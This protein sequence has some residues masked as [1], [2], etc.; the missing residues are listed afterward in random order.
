[1]KRRMKLEQRQFGWLNSFERYQPLG[2]FQLR[3]MITHEEDKL[4]QFLEDP[5]F[6]IEFAS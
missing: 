6:L 4:R 2:L 3:E 1:M 5:L